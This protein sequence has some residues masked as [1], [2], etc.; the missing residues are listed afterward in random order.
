MRFGNAA[1]LG[2]STSVWLLAV[3]F[4]VLA[5]VPRHR[6]GIAIRRP[7]RTRSRP[8]CRASRSLRINV[9]TYGLSGVFAALARALSH[10][11]DGGRLADHRART[12]SCPRSPPRSS[13]ASACSAAR[14]PRSGTMVGAFILTIIGNLVF[15]LSVSSYW[16]PIVSGVIL[17]VA[18]L[19]SS[20]AEKSAR[21]S[22]GVM[23][24]LHRTSRH[25][26]RLCSACSSCCCSPACSRPASSRRDTCGPRRCS[27]RSSASSR[28][29]RPSSSSAAASTCRS[30]GC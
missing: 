27:P 23:G 9:A 25:P 13:A 14:R 10:D 29:A 30:P 26:P 3:L 19:A 4:A 22:L 7:A 1:P 28:S 21:R 5:L 11:A 17:L 15:V 6:L 18:V 16:Q 20:L 24:A 12:T 2:L 8:S